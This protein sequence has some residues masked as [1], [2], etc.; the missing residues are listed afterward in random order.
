M[1]KKQQKI[2][3]EFTAA[4]ATFQAVLEDVPS[5]GLDWA[6]AEGEWTIRQVIHHVAG[7]CDVYSFLIKQALATPGCTHVFDSFPGNEIWAD[8]LGFDT[9]PVGPARELMRAHRH[10]IA[11]LVANF[12]HRWGN[13]VKYANAQGEILAERSVEDILRMLTDHLQQ[14]TGMIKAII[15]AQS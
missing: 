8:R 14:H 12:P 11:E 13:T 3:R 15:Q 4:L 2:L 10:F 7:D 9:R 5:Q 6:A 1:N